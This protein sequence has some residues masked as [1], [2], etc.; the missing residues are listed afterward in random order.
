MT[1]EQ[2]QAPREPQ[3]LLDDAPGFMAVIRGDGHIFEWANPAFLRLISHRSVIGEALETAIPELAAQG[4]GEAL[5]AVLSSGESRACRGLTLRFTGSAAAVAEEKCVDF[6][7]QPLA[8]TVESEVGVSL[9]GYEVTE[10]SLAASALHEEIR[11][12]DEFL[13]TLVHELRNPLAA[14]SAAA[15][16]LAKASTKRE[17]AEM[18]RDALTKQ[19]AYMARLLNDVLDVARITH[20]RVYLRKES[21]LLA[22][23]LAAAIETA[24]PLIDSKKHRLIIDAPA[25]RVYVEGD[26]V[27]LTQV[28]SNLLTNAAKYTDQNGRI[29]LQVKKRALDAEITVRDNGV[30]IAPESLEDVFEMFSQIKPSLR[31]EGGLGVGLAIVRG[32]VQLHG[33]TVTARSEGLG[34]GSEFVVCLPLAQA[35]PRI[36]QA[37]KADG[38]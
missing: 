17:I 36:D 30:G 25:E 11:R 22:D 2:T 23:S 5:D 18:A 16:L 4:L 21:H 33:G 6:I 12:K 31:A 28:F 9:Y 3:Q 19:V 14:L 7:C 34:K 35:V 38:E 37:S 10:R 1:R 13:A 27:H 32:L 20:G 8:A 29:E 26:T 15:H 24:R